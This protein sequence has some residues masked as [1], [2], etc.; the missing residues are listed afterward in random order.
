MRQV[1]LVRSIAFGSGGGDELA[2]LVIL[3]HAR[4][5]VAIG[6]ED[7]AVRVPADIGGAVERVLARGWHGGRSKTTFPLHLDR[8]PGDAPITISTWPCGLNLITMLVP[9]STAQMLSWESTRMAWANE[10]P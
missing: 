3:H 10:R 2:V 1:E 4:I 6:D 7:V 9:S 5:T 8:L